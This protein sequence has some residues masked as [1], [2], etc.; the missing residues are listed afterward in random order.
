MAQAYMPKCLFVAILVVASCDAR[1][2]GDDAK[3]A[4]LRQENAALKAQADGLQ[5]DKDRLVRDK[6]TRDSQIAELLKELGDANAAG[7]DYRH[8]LKDYLDRVAEDEGKMAQMEGQ[9]SDLKKQIDVNQIQIERLLRQQVSFSA[10]QGGNNNGQGGPG[11]R[12]FPPFYAPPG[13]HVKTVYVWYIENA[14]REGYIRGLQFIIQKADGT[15]EPSPQYGDCSDPKL[16][17]PLSIDL[18]HGERLIG[19]HDMLTVKWIDRFVLETTG[20]TM[21]FGNVP[22]NPPTKHDPLMAPR[23]SLGQYEVVGF[24]VQGAKYIDALTL[25][26]RPP[27]K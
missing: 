4:Q 5:S 13:G 11:G 27:Q 26:C 12:P 8:R 10:T 22:P 9:I 19:L 14:R 1:A 21:T 17:H 18:A 24:A 20:Q 7:E 25:V 6:Q 2:Q 15:T 16:R 3:L 23:D